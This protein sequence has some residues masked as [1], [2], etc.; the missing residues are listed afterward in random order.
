[1]GKCF[2]SRNIIVVSEGEVNHYPVGSK[3]QFL[4][5]VVVMGMLSWASYSTGSYLASQAILR[6]KERKIETTTLANRQIEEQF[7][8]LKRDLNKLQGKAG[9]LDEYD[10]FVVEQH[11]MMADA[12]PPADENDLAR[13]AELAHLGQNI[14]QERINYLELMVD[15]LKQ[16]RG[17]LLSSLQQRTGDQIT[18]FEDIIASTGLELNTLTKH[19][20]AKL[21]VKEIQTAAENFNED[22]SA[23]GGPYVPVIPPTSSEV[24]E[25]L[26]KDVDQMLLLSDIVSVLPLAR[27]IENAR[28]S[29]QFG[30]RVD[31][32]TKRWAIHKGMDFVGEYNSP[33]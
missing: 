22:E 4:G 15:Q 31:P 2:R 27:P 1:M 25:N 10:R 17:T 16:E 30:R 23:Q 21:K 9:E 26:F 29:S 7:T 32:I 6:E 8:L 12:I 20:D 33:V 5:L 11:S 24:E 19:A 18:L 3:L 14:L 28:I 13:E